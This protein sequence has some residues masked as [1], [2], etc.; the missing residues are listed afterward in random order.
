MSIEDIPL[1]S[2]T[3]TTV[4]GFAATLSTHLFVGD[5][6]SAAAL[7][8]VVGRVVN[9]GGVDSDA[10]QRRGTSVQD[11]AKATLA[12]MSLSMLQDSGS[13]V[14][15]VIVTVRIVVDEVAACLS[16]CVLPLLFTVADDPRLRRNT[17]RRRRFPS[18]SP[19]L[20]INKLFL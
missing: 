17:S 14:H 7:V 8:D 3:T 13:N 4:L 2:I 20:T 11:L 6:L 10:M 12:T 19:V 9:Y 16:S 1:S 5:S 15:P 18:A